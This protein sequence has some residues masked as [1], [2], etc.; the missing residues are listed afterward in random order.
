MLSP[1]EVAKKVEQKSHERYEKLLATF[2]KGLIEMPESYLDNESF[3]KTDG[4]DLYVAAV[5]IAP[6]NNNSSELDD[7]FDSSKLVASFAT[8]GEILK[9]SLLQ[10]ANTEVKENVKS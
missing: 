4:H 5:S 2:V 8:L 10:L 3:I 9:P 1:L 6:E 7:D